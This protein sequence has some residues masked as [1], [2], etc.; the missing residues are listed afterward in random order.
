[1]LGV[2]CFDGDGVARDYGEAMRLFKS[3]A[4]QP[5]E[6]AKSNI[7]VH[8]AE[9]LLGDMYESGKGTP[10]DRAESV[11]WFRLAADGGYA[12]ARS[13]WEGRSLQG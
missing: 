4:G 12:D 1:M 8:L 5:G 9:S 13:S 2:L 6:W 11:K 7:S 10:V 3:A